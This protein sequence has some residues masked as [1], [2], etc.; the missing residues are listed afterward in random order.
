MVAS[1]P[2]FYVDEVDLLSEAENRAQLDVARPR[3]AVDV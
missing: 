3:G 2:V 1:E